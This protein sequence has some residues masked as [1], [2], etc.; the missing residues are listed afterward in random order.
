MSEFLDVSRRAARAAG[1]VLLSWQDR[2]RPREKGVKDLVTEAD[3][4]SQETIRKI[5]LDAFPDHRFVGEEDTPGAAG[6]GDSEYRWIVDPLDGTVNY[7]HRLQTFS[8]SIALEKA[9]EL[10]CGVVFD[11]VM[12]DWYWAEAGQGA[13]RNE[14]RLQTSDCSA[15]REALLA[16][17]F[18]ANLEPGSLEVRRF[19]QVMCASQAVRRLG[20]A[21][22]NLCYVAAGGLDGYWATSVKAWDVAAGFLIVQEAGGIITGLDGG[23]VSLDNPKF[24]ASANTGLHTQFIEALGRAS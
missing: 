23:D 15:L 21:A 17:S 10:L 24:V 12:D 4:A 2:I 8:V 13:W 19:E 9:G 11:P 1:D 18:S 20:S 14:R 16:A 6:E 3:L 22:L 7:V 5:L